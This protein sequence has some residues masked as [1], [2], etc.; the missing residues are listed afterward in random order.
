MEVTLGDRPD[1]QPG[2]VVF[3]VSESCVPPECGDNSTS[4]DLAIGSIILERLSTENT[5][6]KYAG[7]IPNF[8]GT[9]R[10]IDVML[11]T[12]FQTFTLGASRS[13]NLYQPPEITRVLPNSG[14]RGTNVTLSVNDLSGVWSTVGLSI[15]VRLGQ[16]SADIIDSTDLE[17]IMVRARSDNPG[18][19]YVRINTTY[20]V[21]S[22]RYDGP[23]TFAEDGWTQLMD[24]NITHII[25]PAAQLGRSILLCGNSLLGGGANVS[26]IKHGSNNFLHL[27]S[28][29]TSTVFLP[30]SECLEAT[31]P[32][33]VQET[34]ENVIIVVSDTGAIVESASN[35]SVSAVDTV[36]PSRGQV[37]TL[38]TITGQ[39]LLSGYE[40]VVPTIFLSRVCA[41]LMSASESKIVVRAGAIPVVPPQVI[42]QT[43]G[44]TAP[45]PQIIGVMGEILINVTSPMNSSLSF[46][47]TNSTGW[48]YEEPGMIVSVFPT[49]G[50]YGTLITISGTNLL[51]YGTMLTHATINDVNSTIVNEVTDSMVQ[52]VVPNIPRTGVVDIE[53]FSDTGASVRQSNLF[54]VRE[55]GVVLRA[56]PNQGQNGTVGEV[57]VCK[58][59]WSDTKWGFN[60]YPA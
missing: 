4:F 17:M 46:N 6:L 26:V 2:S 33:T 24:G 19:G 16:T 1:G 56:E 52:L 50:Q 34:D 47:V 9:G 30:G 15:I 44:A 18:I 49:F 59:T 20:T 41:T 13:F 29:P 12:Q 27:Q 39:G 48:Q 22:V 60:C 57:L 14:Q 54:E 53:L 8:E 38:V 37:G 10:R 28:T 51:A 25:P 42:N 3:F 35:F 40:S 7:R 45:P 5:T 58:V 36:I 31:I 23:Y 21:E 43:T 11:I 55:N 32:E